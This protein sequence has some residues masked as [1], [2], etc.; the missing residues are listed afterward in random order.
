MEEEKAVGINH[1]RRRV[2]FTKFVSELQIEPYLH[3]RKLYIALRF[4]CTISADRIRG[5]ERSV[6]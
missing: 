1:A 6:N 3:F 5:T 2:A 4:P